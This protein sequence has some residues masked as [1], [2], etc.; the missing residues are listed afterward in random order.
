MSNVVKF[1][2]K[3]KRTYHQSPEDKDDILDFGQ[4]LTHLETLVVSASHI[5]AKTLLDMYPKKDVKFLKKQFSEYKNDPYAI[6]ILAEMY[7]IKSGEYEDM[8]KGSDVSF[9]DAPVK[10]HIEW[11]ITIL[12]E[13]LNIE[14]EIN[15]P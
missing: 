6:A 2:P 5:V 10:K 3:G 13:R 11:L 8:D 7:S 14:D 15:K 9:V 4:T 12:Q 1:P